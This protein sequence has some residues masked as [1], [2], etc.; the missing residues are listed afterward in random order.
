LEGAARLT[1]RA[2]AARLCEGPHDVIADM[3]LR[4]VRA[5]FSHDSGDLMTQHGR[6]W[7]DIVSSEQ[8]VGVTQA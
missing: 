4:D 5:H 6:Y 8:E 2:S 3:K 7:N 1:P